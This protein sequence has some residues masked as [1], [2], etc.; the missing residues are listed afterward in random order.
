MTHPCLPNKEHDWTPYDDGYEEKTHYQYSSC[1]YGY[2]IHLIQTST[3]KNCNQKM[4]IKTFIRQWD[5]D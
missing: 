1:D 5:A 4:R 2:R 3:C